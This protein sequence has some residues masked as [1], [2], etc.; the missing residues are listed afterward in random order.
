MKSG[1]CQY[2]PDQAYATV[3][4]II[5]IKPRD[6]TQLRNILIKNGVVSCGVDARTF[7]HYGGGIF[8]GLSSIKKCSAEPSQANHAMTVV[9]FGPGH[10]LLR[11]SW[12]EK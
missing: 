8:K 7:K 11:N 10:F 12:G 4:E 2:K 9:G 3:K 6:E 1:P 5:N